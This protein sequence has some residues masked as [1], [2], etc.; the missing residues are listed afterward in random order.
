MIKQ[1]I[2][3]T[4]TCDRCGLQERVVGKV[5]HWARVE[6][7]DINPLATHSSEIWNDRI[8]F[9]NANNAA[10]TIVDLCPL[11]SNTLKQWW[12]EG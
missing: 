6:Q 5:E 12:L 2:T 9:T 3:L 11:C 10:A 1:D 7:T 4:R 8:L